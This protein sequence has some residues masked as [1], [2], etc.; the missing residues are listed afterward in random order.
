MTT[1]QLKPNARWSYEDYL[2]LIDLA[3]KGLTA[4]GIALELYGSES[5][6]QIP[7]QRLVKIGL[8]IRGARNAKRDGVSAREYLNTSTLFGQKEK[9]EVPAEDSA[10]YGAIIPIIITP[11]DMK[12]GAAFYLLASKELARASKHLAEKAAKLIEDKMAG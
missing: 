7:V 12:R 11:P 4:E 9:H 10:Q 6:K 8:S 3:F 1:K 5:Y 2:H